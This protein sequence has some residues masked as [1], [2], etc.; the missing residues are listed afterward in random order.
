[1]P[2]KRPG[3]YQYRVAV[4][5][6]Q[7]GKIGSASQFIEVPD[8]K[9]NRLTASSIVL[10]TYTA[11]EWRRATDPTAGRVPTN[12][13]ADTALRRVKM[14]SVLRYGYE[15]YNAKLSGSKQV[16]VQ[17]KVRI[18]RDGKLILD[19]QQGPVDMRGQIDMEHLKAGGAIALGDKLTPGDYILQIVVTDPLA[20]AKQQLATQFVQFEIVE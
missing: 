5:D 20:K 19:G 11:D 10:E 9:K 4:R 14:G 3:A 7:G 8:L 12:P 1:L 18:F 13:M 16:G 15:I 2:V 6:V 17:I